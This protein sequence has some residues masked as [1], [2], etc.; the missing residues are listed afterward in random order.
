MKRVKVENNVT[1]KHVTMFVHGE[2]EWSVSQVEQIQKNDARG[3][4]IVYNIIHF[5]Y[6]CCPKNLK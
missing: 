4:I 5:G 3:N 2:K 1:K 6:I